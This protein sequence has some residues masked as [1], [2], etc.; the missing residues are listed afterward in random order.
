[1]A[2]SSKPGKSEAEV[3]ARLLAACGLAADRAAPAPRPPARRGDVRRR[4]P[5][6][7]RGRRTGSSRRPSRSVQRTRRTALSSGVTRSR[8]A[9]SPTRRSRATRRTDGRWRSVTAGK[10][11]LTR[12]ATLRRYP[13]VADLELTPETGRT[14]QIRVHLAAKGHPIVGDDFYGGATR[15]RGVR[16]ADAPRGARGRRAPAPP[17]CARRRPGPRRGR[18]GAAPGR[19]RRAPRGARPLRPR[20]R[21]G[22]RGG[23]RRAAPE[24]DVPSRQLDHELGERPEAGGRLPSPA[25]NARGGQQENR[26]EREPG[27]VVPFHAPLFYGRRRRSVARLR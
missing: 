2:T 12:W 15:W 23:P 8:P 1:M 21:G 6:A 14:H 9:A 19:L 3:V 22:G 17:R 11:A 26:R 10:P 7:G 27:E 13:S 24:G 4:P 18:R 5:R 16:D 20:R 25:K